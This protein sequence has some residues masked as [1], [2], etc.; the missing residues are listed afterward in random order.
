[1]MEM[2]RSSAIASAPWKSWKKG[3]GNPA[4]VAQ[5]PWQNMCLQDTAQAPPEPV[6]IP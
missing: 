4:K 1:M 5:N 2:V 6:V 3:L